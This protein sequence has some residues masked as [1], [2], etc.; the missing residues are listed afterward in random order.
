MDQK[1]CVPV[2]VLFYFRVRL[3]LQILDLGDWSKGLLHDTL[4]PRDRVHAQKERKKLVLVTAI[5]AC[6]DAANKVV[7]PGLS[8]R[9]KSYELLESSSE[10]TNL[11]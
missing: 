8:R 3:C 6:G 2:W 10:S 4:I 9:P 1:V 5:R 11:L 7:K